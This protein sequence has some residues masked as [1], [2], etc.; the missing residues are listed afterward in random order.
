MGYNKKPVGHMEASAGNK[1]VGYMAEGSSAYMSALYQTDPKDG[2]STKMKDLP[3]GSKARYDEYNKR[4]W[5]QD[6]TSLTPTDRGMRQTDLRSSS[7]FANISDRNRVP[8]DEKEY[9]KRKEA[10]ASVTDLFEQHSR[11]SKPSERIKLPENAGY[12]NI[13]QRI[14]FFN[15]K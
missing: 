1:A 2:T 3:I 4:N 15:K 12:S 10:G 14:N 5:M 11:F 7:N 13:N 6:E 8:I 9:N